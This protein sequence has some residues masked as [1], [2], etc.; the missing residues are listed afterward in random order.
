MNEIDPKTPRIRLFQSEALEKL[1]LIPPAAFIGV[2]VL[3]LSFAVWKAFGSVDA[4][5]GLGLFSAGLAV[6]TLV[7]Y[8]LH[9]YV[10]HWATSRYLFESLIF[11]IHGN[12]HE[13]PEDPL[14]NLMP[15]IVSLPI[16]A[17]IW[18]GL[19]A[20]FG[21]AGAWFSIGFFVGYVLYDLVHYACHQ[22]SFGGRFASAL[23]RHH[24]R[25]HYVD[26]GRNFAITAIF[27]DRVFGS[28]LYLRDS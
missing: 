7:E 18:W 11:I 6:W 24:L 23:K 8:A 20:T 13:N 12:H 9:R 1:T 4:L 15:P 28:K 25:H 22:V 21:N 10:F 14:R 17:A 27:W 5:T 19:G 26:H 2:W 16:A 3:V